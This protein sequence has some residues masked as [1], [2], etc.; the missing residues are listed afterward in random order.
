MGIFIAL[1]FFWETSYFNGISDYLSKISLGDNVLM[2]GYLNN[3][4]HW[5]TEKGSLTYLGGG[6][7]ID[8]S[9]LPNKITRFLSELIIIYYGFRAQLTDRKLQIAYYFAYIAIIF[10]VIGGDIEIYR[11]IQNW[12]VYLIPVILGI[13]LYK[14]P[15]KLYERYAVFAVLFIYY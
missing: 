9:S 12:F 2:Q 6:A 11:R 5:F 7:F 3:S 4:E 13:A 15:M 14:V 1:F 8:P 10:A